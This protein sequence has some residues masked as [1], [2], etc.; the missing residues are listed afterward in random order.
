MSASKSDLP[1]LQLTD[2]RKSISAVP[3][4]EVEP[5]PVDDDAGLGSYPPVDVEKGTGYRGVTTTNF[6]GLT[7]SRTIHLLSAIQKYSTLPAS[8][9]LILHYTNTALIP[10]ATRSV[11]K[12]DD[13]LLLTRPYYQSFPLEPLLVFAPIIT[14]VVS[15]ISLR[16]YR[17]R[18]IAKRHGAETYRDRRKIPWP[19]VSLTS[20]LGYTLYPMFV[21]HV[22]VN[23]ITPVKVEGNSSGV[24]LRYFAHGVARHPFV[25]N[26]GYATML[27]VASWHIVTGAA[28]FLKLSHEYVIESGD[29]GIRKRRRRSRIVN[30]IAAVV[31]SLWIAGG[32]GVIGRGGQGVGWEA[33]N[34]DGIYKSVPVVGAWW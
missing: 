2:T 31:A 8:L 11:Q 22:L 21:G 9:Y 6:L 25:S 24:G 23:R 28:K 34:W 3:M 33:S 13:L 18:Q 7:P 15:S 12:S 10:L 19:K 29:E 32:L 27:S 26:I 20:A 5:S 16:L 17:R 14:H 1:P 30:G 4:H